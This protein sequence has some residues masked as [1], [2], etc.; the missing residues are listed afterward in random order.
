MCVYGYL[1]S[2]YG[3]DGLFYMTFSDDEDAFRF[4]VTNYY[5][6]EVR[7]GDCVLSEGKIELHNDMPYMNVKE[8]FDCGS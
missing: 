2:A 5:Y 8:L 4:V 3:G 6:Y 1:K 7:S